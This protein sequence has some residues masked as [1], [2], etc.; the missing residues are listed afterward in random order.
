MSARE[1]LKPKVIYLVQVYNFAN[2]SDFI[3]TNIEK[4]ENL[5]KM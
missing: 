1:E 3:E 2:S 5:K 4:L